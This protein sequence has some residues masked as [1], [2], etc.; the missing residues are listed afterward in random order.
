MLNDCPFLESS[1]RWPGDALYRC[2]V[3]VNFYSVGPER[4]LCRTC[5]IAE[6]GDELLCDHLEVFTFH[7]RDAEGHPA[8]RVE[9]ECR[10]PET[11]SGNFP[12]CPI[13]PELR[14]ATE[15]GPPGIVFLG[16]RP[17]AGETTGN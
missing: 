15:G 16:G 9:M 7:Y 17:W 12:R 13:C 4:E 2:S 6:L 10:V 5:P 8:V 3:G 14:Q 1:P 11:R